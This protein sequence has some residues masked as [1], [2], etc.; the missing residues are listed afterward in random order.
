MSGVVGN[1]EE[2]RNFSEQL[3]LY[4]QDIES[5]TW[6]LNAKFEALSENWKDEK[7]AEFADAF[8]EI[9]MRLHDFCQQCED[10]A[11]HLQL[12]ASRLD[13]YLGS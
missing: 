8:S 12:L 13:D 4:K 9:G 10:Y 2:L 6:G 3:L 11:A 7:Q 1:P 5:S